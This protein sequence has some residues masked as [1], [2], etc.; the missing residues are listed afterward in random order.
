MATLN[1]LEEGWE[2]RR[3]K[4]V[5]NALEAMS[6]ICKS[7]KTTPEQKIDAAKVID[8]ISD[9]VLKIYM[10][11]NVIDEAARTVDKGNRRIVDQIKKL[12]DDERE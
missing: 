1:F 7:D 12:R 2:E 8:A 3:S 9:S 5:T 10:T 11:D 6:K 4:H